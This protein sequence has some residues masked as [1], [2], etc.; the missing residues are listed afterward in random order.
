MSEI[1]DIA[2]EDVYKEVKNNAV[3]LVDFYAPWCGPCTILSTRLKEYVESDG[4]VPVI[5]INIDDSIETAREFD[6]MSIPHLFLLDAEGE[7]LAQ[8]RGVM[9]AKNL[10]NWVKENS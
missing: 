4:A 7:V 1:K 6:V 10:E 8:V 5:K 3:T 2:G 9:T